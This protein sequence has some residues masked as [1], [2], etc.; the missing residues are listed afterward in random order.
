MI[1]LDLVSVLHVDETPGR[2]QWEMDTPERTFYIRASDLETRDRWVATLRQALALVRA[3][4]RPT[5]SN[6]VEALRVCDEFIYLL[7]FIPSFSQ[8]KV[9]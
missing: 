7:L 2:F 1:A 6:P 9:G 8:E 5:M 3:K 4:R